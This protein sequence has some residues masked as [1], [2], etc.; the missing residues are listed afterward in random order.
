MHVCSTFFGTTLYI[1]VIR[2]R[3]I[4]AIRRS[5]CAGRRSL[6]CAIIPTDLAAESVDGAANGFAPTIDSAALS[7]GNNDANLCAAVLH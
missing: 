2:Y 1:Y 5:L 6:M 3:R 4:C 7:I